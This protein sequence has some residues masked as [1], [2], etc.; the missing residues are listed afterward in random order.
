MHGSSGIAL[1]TPKFLRVKKLISVIDF[2]I[3]SKKPR[4]R[5]QK[6]LIQKVIKFDWEK[7]TRFDLN[8][9]HLGWTS[10]ELARVLAL[11]FRLENLG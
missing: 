4:N 8:W 2:R 9:S 11:Q 3:S 10:K 5:G 6:S 7:S 1:K